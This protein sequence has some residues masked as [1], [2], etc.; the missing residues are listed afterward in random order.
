MAALTDEQFKHSYTFTL[1]GI[2]VAWAVF[3]V[4]IVY[5]AASSGLAADILTAAGAS[6]L[7]GVLTTID[8][9]VAQHYFR[10]AK[11]E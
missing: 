8:V 7:L 5:R 11:P 6:S 2:T 4:W 10:R 1:L 3:C 9:L